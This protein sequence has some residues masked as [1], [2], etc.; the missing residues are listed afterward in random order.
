MLPS[1]PG[2]E[3]VPALSSVVPIDGD[4]DSASVSRAF[5]AVF[6]LE[7]RDHRRED[8]LFARQ[9]VLR[10]FGIVDFSTCAIDQLALVSFECKCWIR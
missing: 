9:A 10:I 3:S 1:E 8:E 7:H 6:H 4:M 2:R 5:S